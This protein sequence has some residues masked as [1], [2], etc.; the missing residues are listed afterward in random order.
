MAVWKSFS[1]P[2]ND[3]SKDKKSLVIILTPYIVN[4]E[5][6]LGSLKET[7]SKLNKLEHEFAQRIGDK[8]DAN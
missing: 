5:S 1:E 7:L 6:G 2:K 3:D 4:Q 8:K